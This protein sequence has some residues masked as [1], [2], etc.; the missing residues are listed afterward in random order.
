MRWRADKV[1]QF[2][3]Q[4]VREIRARKPRLLVSLS[5]AVHPWAWENYLLDWPAWSASAEMR[6]DEFIPQAYRHSYPAFE[7]TWLQQV[8]AMR[9]HGGNRQRDLL[10]GIRIVGDGSDSSWDQLRRSIELAR[11]TG[12]GGHVLWFS[13]GVLDLYEKELSAFYRETGAAHSPRFAPGWRSPSIALVRSGQARRGM[14]RWQVRSHPRGQYRLIG[15]DG[16]TWRYLDALAPGARAVRVPTKFSP[17]EM[18]LDRRAS[19]GLKLGPR[20]LASLP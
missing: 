12:G 3:I 16:V 5:P 11:T 13:R 17:V 8:D 6:W 4:F 20:G 10:A 9:A 1:T 18:L 7:K 14:Q 15:H 2:A 19:S